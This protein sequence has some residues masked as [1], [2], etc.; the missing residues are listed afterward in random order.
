MFIFLLVLQY[1]IIPTYYCCCSVAQSYLTLCDPVGFSTASFPVLHYL[2]E[3]A[4]THVH[5][6]ND[7]LQQPHSLSPSSSPALNIS[8]HESFPMSQ[9]FSSG[10]QSIGASVSASVPMNIQGWIPLGLTGLISLLSRELL[11]FFSST[12]VW[13][14]QFFSS[15]PSLWYQYTTCTCK[16]TK[17][18]QR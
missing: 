16:Y 14:Y 6:I 12:T 11:R 8:Q 10:G 3:F 4:Q 7:A 5:W 2:P 18:I 1:I 9:L 13:K 17:S 15:Q